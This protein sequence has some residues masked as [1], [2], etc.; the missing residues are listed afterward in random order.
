MGKNNKKYDCLILS[1]VLEHIYDLNGFINNVSENINDDGFLY[2]EIPNADFYE[3]IKN[4]CPLQ[5]VNIEHIN[6]FSKYAINKLLI[7]NGFYCVCLEDD[8]FILKES[9]YFV[10]RGIFKKNINNKSFEKYIDYGSNVLQSYNFDSLKIYENIYIYGCGQLLFKIFDSIKYNCNII[11]I[12]DDNYCYFDK[13]IN[14]VNII[15]YEKF[16]EKCKDGDNVLL[17]TMIYD[18]IIKK[19]LLLIDK[20]INI[21]ELKN[22]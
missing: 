6:F 7:N 19:K 2:I 13:N 8:Y 15:N 3:E 18:E 10:I 9:K 21:I 5:E 12:I 1:H 22:L 20:K 4:I 14:N 16:K 17:T 11:N